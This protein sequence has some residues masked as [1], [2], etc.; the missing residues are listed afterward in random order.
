MTL[1]P[2]VEELTDALIAHLDEITRK[3][4][5]QEVHEATQEVD[6]ISEPRRLR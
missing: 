1:W 2:E 6:E 5:R 3:V 4:I